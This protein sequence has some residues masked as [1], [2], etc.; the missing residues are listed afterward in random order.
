MKNVLVGIMYNLGNNFSAYEHITDVA[1]KRIKHFNPNV[2]DEYILLVNN[3]NAKNCSDMFRH[4]FEKLHNIWKEGDVNILFV[5]S[6]V[7]CFGDLSQLLKGDKMMLYSSG[8]AANPKEFNSGVI[9]FPST[10]KQSVWD[11][12]FK[13]AADWK[14]HWAYNQQIFDAGFRSQFESFEDCVTEIRKFGAFGKFNWY[15]TL[16]H[17]DISEKDAILTHHFSSRGVDRLVELY[18]DYIVEESAPNY[19]YV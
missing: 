11:L 17:K 15:K 3:H 2:F 1:M 5:E 4:Q 7:L 14:H 12:M 6:D 19:R 8:S 13:M 9:Y 16:Y 18:A 10:M